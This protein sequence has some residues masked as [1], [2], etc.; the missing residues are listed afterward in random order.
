LD[1]LARELLHDPRV[2]GLC[3]R[4]EAERLIER[5]G[6]RR[7]LRERA[8]RHLAQLRRGVGAEQ[9]AAAVDH[10]HRLAPRRVARMQRHERQ[11]RGAERVEQRGLRRGQRGIELHLLMYFQLRCLPS[12]NHSIV[13]AMR[14]SRV[15]SVLASVT[16]WRYSRWW[17]GGSAAKNAFAL[18]AFANA[19]L[20]A[21]GT[22][23]G[24]FGFTS[25]FTVTP[26]S[27]SFIAFFT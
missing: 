2:H 16:H 20:S 11:V 18:G 23:I 6:V 22:G 1:R 24:C 13:V 27:F 10:V 12:L 7:V 14:L 15:A 9:V 3:E 26:S 8:P 5:G 21:A 25:R 17:P 4:A 19:A